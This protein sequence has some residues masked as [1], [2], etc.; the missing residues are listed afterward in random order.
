VSTWIGEL[1]QAGQTA[2]DWIE[3]RIAREAIYVNVDLDTID[4]LRRR[5]G[6]KVTAT[7]ASAERILR[8]EFELLGSRPYTPRDPDRPRDD[9]GYV[10]IDWY[11][12][13]V[14]GLR[15]PRGVALPDWNLDAMRPGRADIKYP[16]ELGRCQHFPALGQA[17]VLTGDE[18]YALE[19]ARQVTDFIEANPIGT[20]VN[21]A[22]TMDVGLRAA[23][24]AVGLELVRTSAALRADFWHGAY[25]ALFEHGIFIEHHLENTYEVT[26]NHFLSNIVGLFFVAAVFDDLASGQYWDRQCREWLSQEMA[27]QVLPDGADYES[28]IPYH[29]LV[30]ELFLG[31]A[32]LAEYRGAPLPDAY[33][34]RLRAMV[35]FLSAVERPDGLMPQVGDADDGRLHVMSEYGTWNPQDGRH[36]LAAAGAFFAEPEWIARGGVWGCWEA[37]WWGLGLREAPGASTTRCGVRHFPHAG[38]TVMR[39]AEHYL[40]ITNG[41]VGTAGFGNHKHNDNLGF[42]YHIGGVPILVDCGSYVYTSDP[43]ARNAFRSTAS[44]NTIEIDGEEQNEFRPDWLFR[45]FER[46]SP[47]HLDVSEHDARWTYR[48]RHKGYARFADPVVHERTF[49]LSVAD[50]ALTIA[51]VLEGRGV[52]RIRWYF[53]FA[54]GV[55]VSQATDSAVNILIGGRLLQMHVPSGLA[56]TCSEGWYSS[57]YGVRVPA[58]VLSLALEQRLDGRHEYVFRIAA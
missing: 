57:S 21:W 5:H 6:D 16:W 26:S 23:N 31:A 15:F 40:L 47:E 12:D 50:K 1:A 43:R 51:D 35:D 42:E 22:C 3:R 19:I 33:R 14:A 36:L 13:P 54:P 7:V 41:I 17:F 11:L 39:S 53:H 29:R 46:A 8:H 30:A 9:D 45:M 38:L 28:S 37:A 49:T 27:V 58:V 2:A 24:W 18:R 55:G 4:A 34:K 48:G 32:R 20:A 52:H 44:H 10:P 56:A 25:R